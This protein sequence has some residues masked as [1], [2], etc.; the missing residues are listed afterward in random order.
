[1]KSVALRRYDPVPEKSSC[2][3]RSCG[4]AAAIFQLAH[5]VGALSQGA[6]I[7]RIAADAG[8]DAGDE[9]RVPCRV[10]LAELLRERPS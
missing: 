7:D 4:E 6:V 10:A 3:W 1:V 2:Y 8:A 9:S 5:Q